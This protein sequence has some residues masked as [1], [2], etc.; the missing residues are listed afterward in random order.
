MGKKWMKW[1]LFDAYSH[2]VDMMENTLKK[3]EGI[4]AEIEAIYVGLCGLFTLLLMKAIVV[5]DIVRQY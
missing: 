3:G 1:L 5:A 2:M 4:L